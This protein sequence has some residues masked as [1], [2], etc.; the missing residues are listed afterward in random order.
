[1][2]APGT[3]KSTYALALAMEYAKR[4]CYVFAHDLGFKLKETL[5]KGTPTGIVRHG[6]FDDVRARLSSDPGGIHCI[7]TEDAGAVIEFAK[8]VS[9]ASMATDDKE[10]VG[11]PSL[12]LIDEAVSATDMDTYRLGEGIRNVIS[13]R[14]HYNVGL[15]W[16]S[17]SAGLVN[18]KIM[19]LG[20]E[21]VCFRMN[22][23]RDLDMLSK[24]GLSDEELQTISKLRRFHYIVHRFL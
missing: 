1:L 17:Q 19:A 9:A 2:G 24:A 3:G 8:Q 23:G 22:H 21:L 13:L 14:R 6:S 5:P 16:T 10:G 18:W 20:T 12:V 11:V 4:P 15:I 7:A